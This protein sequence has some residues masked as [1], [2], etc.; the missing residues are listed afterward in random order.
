M[1]YFSFNLRRR[2][3]SISRSV[4]ALLVLTG[5]ARAELTVEEKEEAILIADGELHVLTYHKAD[6]PPPKGVDPIYNRSGFIHPVCAPNGEPLTGIHP[7]DHYHHI[8][9]W[10]A[11][12]KTKHGKDTPDFWNLGRKNAR[13]R[14]IGLASRYSSIPWCCR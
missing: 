12:V 1:H 4:C 7:A 11:W 9:L 10:H 2:N 3:A 8:G 6:V 13:V 5:L 14:S